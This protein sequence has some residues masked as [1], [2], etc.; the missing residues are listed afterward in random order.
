[1]AKKKKRKTNINIKLNEL[2][3]VLKK[4]NRKKHRKLQN[5]TNIPVLA[6]MDDGGW[7]G[8]SMTDPW[9]EW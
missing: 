1:M 4:K 5:T 3:F 8:G 7:G 9:G 2:Y 6:G